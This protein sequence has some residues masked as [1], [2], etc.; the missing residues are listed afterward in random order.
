[1]VMFYLIYFH[2]FL[3]CTINKHQ[4]TFFK[5]HQKGEGKVSMLL[6]T[7]CKKKKKKK[8]TD[9]N[10]KI[11]G[12][13]STF[14]SFLQH[15]RHLFQV[16]DMHVGGEVLFGGTASLT[17]M[18]QR[19]WW[20]S[21]TVRVVNFLVTIPS[22]LPVVSLFRYPLRYL[23]HSYFFDSQK[24]DKTIVPSAPIM[25]RLMN[26][27][28]RLRLPQICRRTVQQETASCSGT[29]LFIEK[30]RRVLYACP[31]LTDLSSCLLGH[32]HYYFSVER[33]S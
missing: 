10:A 26:C 33:G 7:C 27:E 1:M 17:L 19:S 20:S 13:N 2:L 24:R 30:K 3:L 18:E 8:T 32:F 16:H 31:R 23:C 9:S 21:V 22:C 28:C 6:E 29:I 14:S 12:L 25:F 11:C 15:L 5:W 4:F